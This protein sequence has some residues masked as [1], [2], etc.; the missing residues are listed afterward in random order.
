M[1]KNIHSG[2]EKTSIYP[3]KPEVVLDK[4]IA[5]T[6]STKAIENIPSSRELS[7]LVLTAYNWIRI[8]AKLK[9]VIIN[10]FD[11]QAKELRDKI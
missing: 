10:I 6:A 1:L 11:G 4:F 2:W 8:K 3:F 5:K 9:E 7:K